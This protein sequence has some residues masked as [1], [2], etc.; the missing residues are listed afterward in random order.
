MLAIIV[1]TI[2]PTT[3]KTD[4]LITSIASIVDLSVE[5]AGEDG[6]VPA[7][8]LS[9]LEIY[10]LSEEETISLKSSD[11]DSHFAV[12]QVTLS[13]N[14]ESDDY[15]TY[16][17][18]SDSGISSKEG[19]IKSAIDDVVGKYSAQECLDN[20]DAITEECKEAVKGLFNSDVIYDVSFSKYVIS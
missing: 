10:T 13:L 5:G 11:G 16:D 14:T 3:K 19:V 2:I 12:V 20:K 8:A 15:K 9:D 18:S 7:V 17:P 1:F 6:A 4:N